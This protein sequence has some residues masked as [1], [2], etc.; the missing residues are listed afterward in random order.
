MLSNGKRISIYKV[1]YFLPKN[2]DRKTKA[3][4]KATIFS[5]NK[6]NQ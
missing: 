5:D 4:K 6:K 2:I 3:Q 1:T